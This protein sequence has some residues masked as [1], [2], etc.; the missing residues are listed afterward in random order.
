M[1]SRPFSGWWLVGSMVVTDGET[2][3]PQL[4][5]THR[6]QAMKNPSSRACIPS[7]TPEI[8]GTHTTFTSI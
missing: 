8:V 4:M 7:A 2:G 3:V 5:G 1:V 6:R